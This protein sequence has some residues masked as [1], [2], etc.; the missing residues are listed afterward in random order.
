MLFTAASDSP[1]TGIFKGGHGF[2]RFS[3]AKAY[4][5]GNITPGFSI[6][7]MRD[8]VPS[9]NFVSMP[10]LDGQEGKNFFENDYTNHPVKPNGFLLKIVSKKFT[11]ASNCPIMVGLNDCATYKTNGEKESD[12]VFP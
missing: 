4:E 11:Q 2:I 3:M 5:N 8:G 12:V 9:A 6:K 7:F 1:F 10:S